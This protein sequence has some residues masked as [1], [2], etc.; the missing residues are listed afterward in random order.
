MKQYLEGD[1]QILASSVGGKLEDHRQ[2]KCF[3]LFSKCSGVSL[4]TF[5]TVLFVLLVSFGESCWVVQKVNL[6]RVLRK[7]CPAN[8]DCTAYTSQKALRAQPQRQD[9]GDSGRF[10]LVRHSKA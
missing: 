6:V 5:S 8:L 10:A 7:Q 3:C 4:Q 2:E 1:P 9:V